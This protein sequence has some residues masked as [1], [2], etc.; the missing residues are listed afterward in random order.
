MFSTKGENNMDDKTDNNSFTKP[1]T[2]INKFKINYKDDGDDLDEIF[3]DYN[4]VLTNNYYQ[5]KFLKNNYINLRLKNL[6]LKKYFAEHLKQ[7]DYPK[8][9]NTDTEDNLEDSN[10]IKKIIK[11]TKFTI[12][13]FPT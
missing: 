4:E 10:E 12:L 11:E 7:E 6:K 3:P 9:N 2:Y 1:I 5:N 8:H 13:V